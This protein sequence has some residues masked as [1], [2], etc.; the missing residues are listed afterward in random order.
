MNNCKPTFALPPICF[1]IV[2][3]VNKNLELI[4]LNLK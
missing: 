2:L 4:F 3:T 1:I